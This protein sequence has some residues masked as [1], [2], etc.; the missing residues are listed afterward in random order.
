MH[1][2]VI[3]PTCTS[4]KQLYRYSDYCS[5]QGREGENWRG[6][7]GGGGGGMGERVGRGDFIVMRRD[8]NTM[9]GVET[10]S[11][12]TVRIDQFSVIFIYLFIIHV[13]LIQEK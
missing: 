6:K 1:C 11:D 9:R 10:R 4:G 12:N 7:G 5:H 2:T 3:V 8:H 13:I